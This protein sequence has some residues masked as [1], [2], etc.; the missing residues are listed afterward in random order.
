ML[1]PTV[2]LGSSRGRIKESCCRD[3]GHER[4]DPN[5]CPV[6]VDT[7]GARAPEVQ[8]AVQGVCSNGHFRCLTSM[9][10]RAESV[11]DHS[12]VPPDSR[13][14]QRT[15][16]ISSSLLPAHAPALSDLLKMPITLRRSR[17]RGAARHGGRAWRHD[18]RDVGLTFGNCVVDV[19]SVVRAVTRKRRDRARLIE[20]RSDLGTVI[21]IVDIV[22]S[23]AMI[24]PGLQGR[25]PRLGAG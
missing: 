15:P 5:H 9:R 17:A 23:V 7:N 11:A 24:I 6:S 13:F 25:L 8:H 1:D 21:D 14:D 4:A 18:D 10:P 19:V 2:L 3:Q 12:F 16:I 22:S 20:Q